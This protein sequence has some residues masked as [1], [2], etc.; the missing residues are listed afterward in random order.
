MQTQRAIPKEII[1]NLIAE[2]IEFNM[3]SIQVP[4]GSHVVVRFDNKD[5]GI[6]HNFAVY[7]DDTAAQSI[8]KGEII[9]GPATTAY[10]FTAP[11]Q[12]GKYFFRC[13][14]HP[15]TMYGDFIVT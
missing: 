13:D 8:F 1:I 6:P 3:P 5:E 7:Q 4:A 9:T 10:V 14:I 11:S 15:E 12:P 2:N